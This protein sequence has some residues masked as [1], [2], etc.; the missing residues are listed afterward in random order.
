MNLECRVT[1]DGS[2]AGRLL[3]MLHILNYT[4]FISLLGRKIR[5]NDMI[6]PC[7]P[8]SHTC[9]STQGPHGTSGRRAES[10]ADVI[11]TLLST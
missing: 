5:E 6:A 10:K 11:G 2:Q 3:L 1:Q 7:P 4:P 9:P 8:H